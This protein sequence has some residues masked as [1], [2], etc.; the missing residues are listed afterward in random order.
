MPSRAHYKRPRQPPL[1][2]FFHA[3]MTH[4]TP[5][6]DVTYDPTSPPGW[7]CFARLVLLNLRSTFRTP[8]FAFQGVSGP[9]FGFVSQ[10]GPVRSGAVRRFLGG[11]KCDGSLVT[12]KSKTA[13]QQ[14]YF[15]RCPCGRTTNAPGRT[16]GFVWRNRLGSRRAGRARRQSARQLALFRTLGSPVPAWHR[17][18]PRSER[19]PR[20]NPLD[21]SLFSCANIIQ[22]PRLPVK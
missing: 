9:G 12:Q 4:V 15:P 11:R 20:T 18:T 13:H 21:D 7:L 10:S 17:P 22:M 19:T 16:I 3:A 8:H 2:L 5:S 1:A 6:A 14:A